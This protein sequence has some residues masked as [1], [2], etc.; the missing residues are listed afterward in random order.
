MR[1]MWFA[2]LLSSLCRIPVKAPLSS[3]R[4]RCGKIAG[5]KPNN[6]FGSVENWRCGQ[7]LSG[8]QPTQWSSSDLVFRDI[9]T[10]WSISIAG[11]SNMADGE[12]FGWLDPCDPMWPLNTSRVESPSLLWSMVEAVNTCVTVRKSNWCGAFGPILNIKDLKWK[13]ER[14][15]V[16]GQIPSRFAFLRHCIF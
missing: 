12:M 2:K 9:A 6:P 15:P 13:V 10:A 3:M 14:N 4:D 8:E 16:K 5:R 7:P 1:V 11:S